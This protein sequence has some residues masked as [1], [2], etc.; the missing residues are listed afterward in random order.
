MLCGVF[1]AQ[2]DLQ[3]AGGRKWATS[4]S[5]GFAR[6]GAVLGLYAVAVEGGERFEAGPLGVPL[7]NV[8][9]AV[10]ICAC[11]ESSRIDAPAKMFPSM[12]ETTTDPIPMWKLTPR[13]VRRWVYY[14]ASST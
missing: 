14:V 5:K 12:V 4:D 13:A 10:G 9:S 1:G 6:R 3:R 11:S 8:T 7:L 2:S